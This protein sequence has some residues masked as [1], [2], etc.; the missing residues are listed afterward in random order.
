MGLLRPGVI[1]FDQVAGHEQRP[2]EAGPKWLHSIAIC[3]KYTIDDPISFQEI[4]YGITPCHDRDRSFL[5]D[6]HDP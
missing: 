6:S 2:R 1:V 4:A 3:G 5:L